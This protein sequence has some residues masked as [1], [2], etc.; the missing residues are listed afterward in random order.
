[1]KFVTERID[2]DAPLPADAKE[3]EVVLFRVIADLF[4]GSP[5]PDEAAAFFADKSPD[6]VSNLAKL[7][8]TR[9]WY[10]SVT[11]SIKSGE[12][13]FRVVPEDPEAAART[14][15]A[16]NPGHYNLGEQL[17][18]IVSRR[19]EGDRIVNEANIVWFPPGKENVS[20]KVPLPDS[21]DTW[22]AGWAP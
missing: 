4:G 3:R 9:T 18:F 8:S 21:F 19:P 13:Q 22:V 5:T 15:V 6:A 2:R 12:T 14:R 16:M 7:L 10:K 20:T 17:R 11:G 1:M